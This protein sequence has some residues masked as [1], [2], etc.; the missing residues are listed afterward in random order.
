MRNKT[1][2]EITNLDIYTE[3]KGLRKDLNSMKTRMRINTWIA[4]TSLTLVVGLIMGCV[5]LK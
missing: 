1:F 5:I 2:M 4:S 3:L